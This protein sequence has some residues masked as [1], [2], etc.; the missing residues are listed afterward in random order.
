MPTQKNPPRCRSH[1]IL[2]LASCTSFL[3][4]GMEAK[5]PVRN[6]LL[7]RPAPRKAPIVSPLSNQLATVTFSGLLDFKGVRVFKVVFLNM[8]DRAPTRPLSRYVQCW[9]FNLRIKARWE[10][11]CANKGKVH[12]GIREA[13][14]RWRLTSVIMYPFTFQQ[15]G[16][17]G[18]LVHLD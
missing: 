18:I 16:Y 9:L 10:Y 2:L 3:T 15:V 5:H 17:I 7:R 8:L 4:Q 11:F 12:I 13:L 1:L 14:E 6:W